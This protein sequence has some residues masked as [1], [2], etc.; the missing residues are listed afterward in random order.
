MKNISKALTLILA[1]SMIAPRVWAGTATI[2]AS[3]D[4]SIFQNS[5]SNSAGGAAGVFSGANGSASP[6]RGLMAFDIAA[7]VPSGATIT[8]AKLSLYLGNAPN[9]NPVT[10]GLHKLN[11]DWGEGTAGSSTPAI[12]GGG[13]GS[14][15]ATGD[16][17]WN[18]R[19]LGTSLWTDPG[20][21]GDFNATAS[22]SATVSG[23]VDTPYSWLST[24]ALVADVQSWLNTPAGNFG[25][26]LIN[27][28]EGSSATVKAFYSRSATLNSNGGALN[29]DW[30]PTLVVDY[31]LVPEPASAILLVFGCLLAF[32]RRRG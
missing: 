3:K 18:A 16:A 27:A 13:N 9:F 22:A 21:T 14:A 31:V 2:S 25:W 4:N 11:A 8:S 6:R 28:N 20:A 12:S 5:T 24:P 32:D 15:A 10:I 7:S 17:T 26:V 1:L 19:V 23:P 30:R 29:L